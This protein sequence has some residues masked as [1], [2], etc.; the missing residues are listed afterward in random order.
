MKAMTLGV[1]TFVGMAAGFSSVFLAPAVQAEEYVM[2]FGHTGEVRP[3]AE[4]AFTDFGGT[5]TE[6]HVSGG[7]TF[8][9]FYEDVRLNNNAGFDNPSDGTLA[10]AR[11]RDVLDTLAT[12]LNDTGT[13]D[14]LFDVSQSDA[15]GFL[16]S[17]GSLYSTSAGFNTP[18]SLTRIQTGV[19]PSPTNPEIF[20]TVDFGFPYNLTTDPTDI[21]EVDFA[22]VMLH[23][24]THGLGI[25][26]VTTSTGGSQLGTNSRTDFDAFLVSGQGGGNLFNASG[27]FSV[28]ASAL[29]SNNLFFEGT[30]ATTGYNQPAPQPGIYAPVAFSSGSSISHWD[31]GNIVGG[32]VMEHAITAGTDRRTYADVDLGALKDIGWDNVVLGAEGEGEGTAEGATEGEPDPVATV[33]IGVTGGSSIEEGGAFSLSAIVEGGTASSFQWMRGGADLGGETTD[34]LERNSA[35]VAD[36]GSYRV[37]IESGAKAIV[38]SDPVLITVVPVGGLPVGGSLALAAVAVSCAFAGSMRLRKRD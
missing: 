16:A 25:A 12:S 37:R 36:S 17:A 8:R 15:S 18:T 6:T 27:V 20:V 3:V 34:T 38:V 28:P 13:L 29:T 33:S 9:L 23:E 7:M 5:P 21:I 30:N 10:R 11:V 24:F 1:K 32:A 4:K 19:K 2:V 22:S 35:T 26:S 14:I 31:T